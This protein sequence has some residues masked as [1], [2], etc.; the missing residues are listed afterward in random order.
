MSSDQNSSFSQQDWVDAKELHF[1]KLPSTDENYRKKNAAGYPM[2]PILKRN[3]PDV[4]EGDLARNSL[5]FNGKKPTTKEELK[6]IL[7]GMEMSEDDQA[8]L[9]DYYTQEIAG[10]AKQYIVSLWDTRKSLPTSSGYTIEISFSKE[11]RELVFETKTFF[12]TQSSE[13]VETDEFIVEETRLK[14]ERSKAGLTEETPFY[15][16]RVRGQGDYFELYRYGQAEKALSLSKSVVNVYQEQSALNEKPEAD[17]FLEV[18]PFFKNIDA[19][20][21]PKTQA[22][23]AVSDAKPVIAVPTSD[24]ILGIAL[25]NLNI[26]LGIAALGVIVLTAVVL[27][28][29]AAA[30]PLV[31]AAIAAAASGIVGNAMLTAV[32]ATAAF[33]VSAGLVALGCLVGY[34]GLEKGFQKKA[35]QA[36]EEAS[37]SG[38]I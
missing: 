26:A 4:L 28:G 2:L 1:T 36:S 9:F 35:Y 21:R 23:K 31:G 32:V 22:G 12:G 5:I 30:I 14:I 18:N 15:I 25:F 17:T 38:C 7:E 20:N 34:Q 27:T 19:L 11:T 16:K 6:E 13:H 37:K 3:E 29:G 33:F 24:R 10:H 8:V